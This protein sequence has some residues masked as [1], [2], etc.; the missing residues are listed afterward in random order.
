M[1]I[2]G[3][4]PPIGE[5]DLDKIV[6]AVRNL[7]ENGPDITTALPRKFNVLTPHE[8]LI[9]KWVTTAT[10]DVDA[11]AVVLFDSSGNPKRFTSL[12]ETLNIAN[13]GANGLDTG[14]EA[15]STW[16]YIWVIGK[17]D[18]TLD[19]LLS[20]SGSSPTLPTDYIYKGVLGCVYNNSS[21]NLLRFSQAGDLFTIENTSVLSLATSTS[22]ADVDLSAVLPPIATECHFN[23]IAVSTSGTNFVSIFLAPAGS[24]TTPTYG[25]EK[26]IGDTVGLLGFRAV[27]AVPIIVSQTM[28]Y[29]VAGTNAAASGSVQGGRY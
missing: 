7:Y 14:S 29:R 20:T 24:S 4:I 3:Y 12:N 17:A 27:M 11:D 26:A 13:S 21:S 1:T 28:S 19:A 25:G 15:N 8:S 5:R 22:Y 18:G 16:Y 10:V 2:P 6:R 23:G 9:I